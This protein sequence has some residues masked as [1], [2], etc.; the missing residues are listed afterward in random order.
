MP[1]WTPLSISL[2]S[3]SCQQQLDIQ[4]TQDNQIQTDRL[5]LPVVPAVSKE[6]GLPSSM[7]NIMPTDSGLYLAQIPL[8]HQPSDVAVAPLDCTIARQQQG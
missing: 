7:L 8:N 2:C 5:L 3:E 1:P 4:N 6:D